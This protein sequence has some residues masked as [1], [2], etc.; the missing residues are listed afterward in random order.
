MNAV[1]VSI[2]GVEYTIGYDGSLQLKDTYGQSVE[3]APGVLFG[4]AVAM[5]WPGVRS[6]LNA[7][8]QARQRQQE[9][10]G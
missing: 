7:A 8:E 3:L 5:R 6:I 4:L 9:G 1:V 2:N 10:E